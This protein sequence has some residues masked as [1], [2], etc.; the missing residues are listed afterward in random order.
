[1]LKPRAEPLKPPCVVTHGMSGPFRE[2]MQ[3]CLF[4]ESHAL[5]TPVL[6]PRTT[7]VME[8]QDMLTLVHF[9]PGYSP[10]LKLPNLVSAPAEHLRVEV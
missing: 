4:L 10:I 8:A 6:V 7:V 3:C 2:S 5:K 1:M 9:P